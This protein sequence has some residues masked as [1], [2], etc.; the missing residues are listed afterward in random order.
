MNFN[1]CE[2]M[3]LTSQRI[4]ESEALN[5]LTGPGRIIVVAAG[6]DGERACYLEKRAEE[7]KRN[8]FIHGSGRQCSYNKRFL[9]CYH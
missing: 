5:A 1:I 4:L 2:S 6:N 3:M 8:V 9:R 7:I